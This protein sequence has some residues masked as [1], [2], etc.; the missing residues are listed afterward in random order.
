MGDA[1]LDAVPSRQTAT[2]GKSHAHPQ[3]ALRVLLGQAVAQLSTDPPCSLGRAQ[4]FVPAGFP[5]LALLPW[6]T[7]A[8]AAVQA[9]P[10]SRLASS[11][12]KARHGWWCLGIALN[13]LLFLL[14]YQKTCQGIFEC[15][16]NACYSWTLLVSSAPANYRRVSDTEC[17]LSSKEAFYFCSAK[18]GKNMKRAKQAVTIIWV[19][20]LFRAWKALPRWAIVKW[21][22]LSLRLGG[23]SLV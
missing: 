15:S 9:K 23:Y 7:E 12:L 3:P 1:L 18:L 10:S 13:C 4:A 11:T 21:P 19:V 22:L 16:R 17:A 5:F 8:P 14:I 20:V 6:G 2:W